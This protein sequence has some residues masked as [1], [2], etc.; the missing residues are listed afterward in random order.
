MKCLVFG[1]AILLV[2]A[3]APAQRLPRAEQLLPRINAYVEQ[4]RAAVPSFEADESAVVER[5]KGDQ[6]KQEVHLDMTLRE[7]RDPSARGGFRDHYTF[8]LVDGNA[9]RSHFKLPY[10]VQDVFS[11]VIGFGRVDQQSCFDYRVSSG[12]T[13]GTVQLEMSLKPAPLPPVCSGIFEN[14]RKTVVV[15]P[16]TGAIEHV[17]RSMSASAAHKN[18]EIPF[19]SLD[20][21]PQDLGG[22]TFWLPIRFDACDQSPGR[23]MT[24]TYSNFHRFTSTSRILGTSP[25]PGTDQ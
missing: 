22:Q 18:H 3:C 12:P 4:Y 24:A 8:H 13:S 17:T 6:V 15:D 9:P 21:A 11:N 16:S 1:S 14:Y 5:L 19:L 7:E 20:Y 25:A 10:F 2:A 23:R